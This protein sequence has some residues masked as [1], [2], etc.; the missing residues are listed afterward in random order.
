MHSKFQ[1]EIL[2][3]ETIYF[4]MLLWIQK[5][6]AGITVFTLDMNTYLFIYLCITTNPSQLTIIKSAYAS[7]CSCVSKALKLVKEER[8]G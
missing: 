3:V 1:V 6:V 7:F 4:R 8:R 2:A 5:S